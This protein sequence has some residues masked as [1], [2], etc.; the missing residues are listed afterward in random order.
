MGCGLGWD[1]I[2]RTVRENAG[3]QSEEHQDGDL[4]TN[5]MSMVETTFSELAGD[6]PV[7]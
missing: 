7:G 4:G 3:Q 5:T 2:T 1:R 6:E